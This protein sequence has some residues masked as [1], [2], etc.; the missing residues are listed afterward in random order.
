MEP[1]RQRNENI[2]PFLYQCMVEKIHTE[3]IGF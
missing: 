3:G 2:V 1:E